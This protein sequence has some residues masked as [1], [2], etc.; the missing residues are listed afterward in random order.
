M[1]LD[2]NFQVELL[3]VFLRVVA[4]I[5]LVAIQN[6]AYKIIFGPEVDYIGMVESGEVEL[7]ADRREK[8]V[9]RFAMEAVNNDRFGP[10]WFPVATRNG[11]EVRTSTRRQYQ[12]K[13]LVELRGCRIIR[14]STWLES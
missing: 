5:Y 13:E 3:S 12:N 1:V 10:R 6:Q 2:S 7:L 14:C 9:L 11:R 4:E 8:N